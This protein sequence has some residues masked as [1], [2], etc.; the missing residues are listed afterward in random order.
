MINIKNELVIRSSVVKQVALLKRNTYF[1]SKRV[2]DF[3]LALVIAILLLPMMLIIGIIIRFGSPGPAIFTQKRVGA[4]RTIVN[5]EEIWETYSFTMYKFRSMHNKASSDRHQEFITAYIKNNKSQM[6]A[7]NVGCDTTQSSMYKLVN[8]PRVTNIGR[9]MRKTSLDELPQ[10]W[11]V[12]R[13]DM[14]LV[15]PRPAIEYEVDMYES[16]HLKRLSAKPGLTGLWQI[17]G[18]S[19]TSFDEMVQL[20]INY[21]ENQSMLLDLTIFA[22]TPISVLFSKDAV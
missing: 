4:K 19:N 21:V 2:V 20:D 17:E 18:R 10:L 13:G 15:G 9:F 7:M 11:N 8:D 12:I 16:W 14:S 5:G 1:A 3:V 6:D 22:L